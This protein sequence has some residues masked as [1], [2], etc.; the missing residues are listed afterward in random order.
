MLTP[1]IGAEAA[2]ELVTEDDQ[3]PVSDRR[4]ARVSGVG[5]LS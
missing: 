5:G 4:G 1:F 2:A 3:D